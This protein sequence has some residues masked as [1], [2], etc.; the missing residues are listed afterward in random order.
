M[1]L[2]IEWE[3]N[4]HKSGHNQY[5][6]QQVRDHRMKKVAPYLLLAILF[7]GVG[8]YA[9]TRNSDPVH[10]AA[11]ESAPPATPPRVAQLPERAPTDPDPVFQLKAEVEPEAVAEP[12]LPLN[13]SDP[14]FDQSLTEVLGSDVVEQ[15]LVKGDVISRLVSTLDSLTARQV[16]PLI[17][18]VKSADDKMLVESD[19]DEL[20]LS[21]DNYARYDG[22]VQEL[23]KTDSADLLNT[24]QR[25]QPLFQKAWIDNGGQGSFTQRMVEVIDELLATPDVPQ[26]VYVTKPE[27]VYVFEDPALEAMPAGQKILVRMGSANAVVVKQKLAEIK[28]GLLADKSEVE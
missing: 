13:E 14:Q 26:P 27:A 2:A 18:P 15:F 22:Y 10:E 3:L 7:A 20:I 28:A 8:W 25:Y 24:Y 9:L 23:Q 11:I 4:H 5:I 17:N 21:A 1:I 12:L 19:G 16:P 6:K